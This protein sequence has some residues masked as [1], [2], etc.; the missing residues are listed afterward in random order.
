MYRC[1]TEMHVLVGVRYMNIIHVIYDDIFF[2]KNCK[3]LMIL[4]LTLLCFSLPVYVYIH[5]VMEEI[6]Q[7][8][9]F[10]IFCYTLSF[11]DLYM[12]N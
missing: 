2:V 9:S 8:T 5:I 12:F 7:Y 11:I 10:L 4:K 1:M 6:H 3:V